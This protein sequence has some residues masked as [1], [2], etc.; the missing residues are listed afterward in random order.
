MGAEAVGGVGRRGV[1][2]QGMGSGGGA[3]RV[4]VGVDGGCS[5][6]GGGESKEGWWGG[7]G[8]W[9]DGGRERRGWRTGPLLGGGWV[10]RVGGVEPCGG[11]TGR[12][13]VVGIE[14]RWGEYRAAFR[15]E[16]GGGR[17]GWEGRWCGWRSPA[18]VGCRGPRGAEPVNGRRGWVGPLLGARSGGRRVVGG[19]RYWARRIEGGWEVSE[20]D[21]GEGVSGWHLGGGYWCAGLPGAEGSE[22]GMCGALGLMLVRGWGLLSGGRVAGVSGPYELAIRASWAWLLVFGWMCGVV[23]GGSLKVCWAVSVPCWVSLHDLQMVGLR[24]E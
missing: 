9:C 15:G 16:E 14:R 8:D 23:V 4:E 13:G 2:G 20:K 5:G 21:T 19:G 22:Y 10:G 18:P 1:S 17:L 7:R 12:R 11:K 24:V 3:G 6:R